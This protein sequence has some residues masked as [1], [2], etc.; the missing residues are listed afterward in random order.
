MELTKTET[1]ISGEE[2]GEEFTTG[3][4]DG[5]DPAA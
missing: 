2:P 4:S 1:A 5:E 3:G